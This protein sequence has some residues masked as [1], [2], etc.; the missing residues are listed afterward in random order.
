MKILEQIV[1][2]KRREVDRLRLQK[3]A[4]HE[5]AAERQ[6]YRDFAGALRNTT[7][8]AL[9]AEVK[10]ASPSAGVIATNFQPV[11]IAKEYRAAGAAALSVLT[12]EKFFQGR[13][14]YLQQIRAV[15]KL[16]VLRKDF[17]VDELQIYESVA[18]GADAILL[19]V[20]ILDGA[21]LRQYLALARQLKIPALV[22]V[23]DEEELQ[24]A[25]D[26][27]AELIG[28]N[29]RDL[30]TFTVDLATTERLASRVPSDRL[31]VAESGI[32]TRADVE[33]VQRAG[34][35]AILVGESL[36]RSNDVAA[37]VRE[38]LGAPASG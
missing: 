28:I 38:L 33:R 6:D 14:E 30:R 21:Q 19:I 2:E 29:N 31:V 35:K 34:V 11:A 16:P 15:V 13:I 7:G 3:T 37:K 5:L 23:H 12:D 32:H 18:R 20:A 1:A 9:I 24:R 10:K 26:S 27:G 17:I 8:L 22:E 4:I 36:M 25:L